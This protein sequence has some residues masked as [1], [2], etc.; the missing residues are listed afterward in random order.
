[1]NYIIDFEDISYTINE[2]VRG[3]FVIYISRI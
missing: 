2:Y 3:D 1:M